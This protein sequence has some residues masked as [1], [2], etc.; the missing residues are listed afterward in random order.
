M[1]MPSQ[2][3]EVPA[4][5]ADET[6]FE[7]EYTVVEP[8]DIVIWV[9]QETSLELFNCTR[10]VTRE[11]FLGRLSKVVIGSLSLCQWSPRNRHNS[12]ADPDRVKTLLCLKSLLVGV[13]ESLIGLFTRPIL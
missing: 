11:R 8:T 3:F 12:Q 7:H 1:S 2:H 9:N 5:L 10:Q 6:K 4:S 13:I